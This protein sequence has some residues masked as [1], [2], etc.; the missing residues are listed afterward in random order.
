[1]MGR[2]YAT[3]VGSAGYGL[4]FGVGNLNGWS[5]I[6]ARKSN[7]F[8]TNVPLLLNPNGGNVGIGT[9]TPSYSLYVNGTAYAAGA[10]GALSDRRH[11]KDIEPFP[12]G[13]LDL[14]EALKPVTFYW[15]NPT[16][17][18]MKGRQIGF[19]AQDVQPIIPDAV[20]TEHNAEQ[21]L[22]LKYD[23]LIPIL[24]KAIQEQQTEI[25]AL[26]IANGNQAAQIKMLQIQITGQQRGGNRRTVAR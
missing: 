23:S 24:A 4:D 5:W 22:G 19:I 6:Q 26:K 14:V 1:M 21:T 13:A 18:G 16:D 8:T 20:I 3:N 2:I 15:K 10:A 9:L 25:A 11:K 7:D 17:D 12:G